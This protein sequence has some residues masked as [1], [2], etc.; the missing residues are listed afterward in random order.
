M[1]RRNLRK[2]NFIISKFDEIKDIDQKHFD[3]QYLEDRLESNLTMFNPPYNKKLLII[4]IKTSVKEVL[5]VS[6]CNF[7][8]NLFVNIKD[9]E[10]MFEGEVDVN[11]L[12][13]EW[14]QLL[15][16][17]KQISLLK[18]IPEFKAVIVKVLNEN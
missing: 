16:F 4:A 11:V 2:F 17:D 15:D 14:A 7:A 9:I 8:K 6:F 13:F 3:F 5:E 1:V 10:F 12:N 18:E